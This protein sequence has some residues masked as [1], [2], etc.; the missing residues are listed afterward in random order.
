MVQVEDILVVR[1]GIRHSMVMLLMAAAR[2]TR[3]ERVV[4]ELIILVVELVVGGE[5]MVSS[6]LYFIVP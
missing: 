6:A 3:M 4:E 1:P 5:V 2:L